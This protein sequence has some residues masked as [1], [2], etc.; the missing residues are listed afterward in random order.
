MQV[1]SVQELED[2]TLKFEGHLSAK[3]AGIVVA[4]GLNT[5]WANG[6]LSM[7]N[8]VDVTEIPLG[9]TDEDTVQ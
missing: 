6:L 3:E 5:L 2:R 7:V 9:P 1:N 4:L 8:D